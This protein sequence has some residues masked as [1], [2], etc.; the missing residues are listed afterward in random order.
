MKFEIISSNPKTEEA[1]Q[2]IVSHNEQEFLKAGFYTEYV[3]IDDATAQTSEGHQSKY[4]LI[5]KFVN[6]MAKAGMTNPLGRS[7][8]LKSM[9][10]KLKKIDKNIKI[11]YV[12]KQT[13]SK[14]ASG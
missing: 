13:H 14:S 12:K 6:P 9:K 7:I 1:L 2:Q 8:M 11:N 3:K 4:Y 5:F 10:D